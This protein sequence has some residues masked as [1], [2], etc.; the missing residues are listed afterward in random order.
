MSPKLVG[1]PAITSCELAVFLDNNELLS[2]SNKILKTLT[3]TTVTVIAVDTAA[4]AHPCRICLFLDNLKNSSV[5]ASIDLYN[6]NWLSLE[7][8]VVD[9]PLD[10]LNSHHYTRVPTARA[11]KM[12]IVWAY[13]HTDYV[14][15]WDRCLFLG[16]GWVLSFCCR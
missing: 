10:I 14:F 4:Q 8:V 12:W 9:S 5:L 3:T 15:L 1:R 2:F 7:L 16:V 13:E 6:P 11:R